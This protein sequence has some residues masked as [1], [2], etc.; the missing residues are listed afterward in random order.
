[1]NNLKLIIVHPYDVY[2]ELSKTAAAELLYVFFFGA[3][4]FFYFFNWNPLKKKI[5]Y[6]NALWAKAIKE[7]DKHIL[8]IL[9]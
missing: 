3:I 9:F 7:A 5:K 2:L 4:L 8:I 1:M 6:R